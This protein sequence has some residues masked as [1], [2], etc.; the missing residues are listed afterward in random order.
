MV[1]SPPASRVAPAGRRAK[2][3]KESNKERGLGI[4]GEEKHKG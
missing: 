3:M 4:E 1:T 2:E